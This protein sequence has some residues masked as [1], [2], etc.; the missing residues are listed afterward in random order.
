MLFSRK[1]ILFENL[2]L[3]REQLRLEGKR[4]VLTN[5]CFD[6]LHAGHVYSLQQAAS[7]GDVLWVGLNSDESVRQLKGPARPIYPENARLYLLNALEYVH[8]IF[9]FNGTNL[10]KEMALI[11]PDVY[12]KS[13]D[14]TLDTLNKDE[15]QV[16]D[17]CGAK[18]VFLPFLEGWSTSKTIKS[19]WRKTK[20]TTGYTRG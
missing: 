15:K 5:G 4:L 3:Q 14:Y 20:R 18:I 7:Q 10:S 12:V 9:L 17:A 16:L 11:R 1:K 13:G 8:G 6:L 19:I 2:A